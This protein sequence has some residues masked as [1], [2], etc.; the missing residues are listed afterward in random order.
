MV[1]EVRRDARLDDAVTNGAL[2]LA[3]QKSEGRRLA[4]LLA[5]V[6]VIVVV[7]LV[8]HFTHGRALGGAAYAPTLGLL[9]FAVAYVVVLLV[10]VR[11]AN[12]RGDLLPVRLWVFSVVL[13]SLLPTVAILILQI[14]SALPPLEALTSPALV[15]YGTLILLSSLRMRPNLCLLSGLVSALGHAALF[16][17]AATAGGHEIPAGECAYY[18][19]YPVYL[20]LM[21]IAAAIVT[22]AVRT[23]FLASLRE[24]ATRRSLDRMEDEME[25]A[26]GIQQGLLPEGPPSFEGYDIAGWNRPADRTGGDYYDWQLLPDGRLAVLIADVSGHGL[27]PALLMAVC[28]AYARASLPAGPELASS[29]GRVNTLLHRDVSDGRFVTLAAA[30]LGKDGGFDLLSAGHGPIV[31]YRARDQSFEIV[32]AN[33]APLGILEEGVFRAAH[34]FEMMQGD[35]LLFVT[36]GFVETRRADGQLYETDRLCACLRANATLPADQLIAKLEADVSAFAPGVTQADDMTA[37]AIRR[38]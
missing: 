20:A 18:L 9:G 27:G 30:V 32:G 23:Y 6:A 34:R 13:E 7:G 2:R 11:R 31:L 29:L 3:L 28:R 10:V 21:G 22:S 1:A 8:R 36:D 26:R 4:V 15:Q 38:L 37:V 35:V 33:G 17:H 12:A 25:A 16:F 24:A 5:L 14:W 19:S